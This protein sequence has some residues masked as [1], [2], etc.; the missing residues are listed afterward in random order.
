MKNLPKKAILAAAAGPHTNHVYQNGT[1]MPGFVVVLWT[2]DVFFP[3]K[4]MLAAAASDIYRYKNIALRIR[5]V[6]GSLEKMAFR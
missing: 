5:T 2:V 1:R 3:K 6:R 4:T